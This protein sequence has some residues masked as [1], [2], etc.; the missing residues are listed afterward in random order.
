MPILMPDFTLLY[1]YYI[2][3]NNNFSKMDTVK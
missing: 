2:Y 3:N 1:I